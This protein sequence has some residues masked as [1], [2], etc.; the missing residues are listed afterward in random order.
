MKLD[1]AIRL[2]AYPA[3]SISPYRIAV[4]PSEGKSDT[5]LSA[6]ILY[7]EKLCARARRL[8]PLC[9]S[10]GYIVRTFQ[11]LFPT[12]SKLDFSLGHYFL[13]TTGSS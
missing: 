4:F 1:M 6:S 13:I 9:E 5:I 8:L 2:T 11:A 12:K 3:R 7:I 10:F